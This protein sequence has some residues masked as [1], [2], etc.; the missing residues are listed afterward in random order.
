MNHIKG[1][2]LCTARVLTNTLL[3][4]TTRHS[5]HGP[6]SNGSGTPSAAI[7]DMR[8]KKLDKLWNEVRLGSVFHPPRA[9]SKQALSYSSLLQ[10]VAIPVES[11][12]VGFCVV[13]PEACRTAA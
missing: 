6:P 12:E 4:S 8:R 11:C 3:C 2:A 7:C 10:V 9:N 1:R 13:S 5:K